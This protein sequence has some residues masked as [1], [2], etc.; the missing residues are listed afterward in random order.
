MLRQMVCAVW[1]AGTMLIQG[2][3]PTLKT[4]FVCAC[5]LTPVRVARHRL[6]PSGEYPYHDDNNTCWQRSHTP[7]TTLSRYS[8][9]ILA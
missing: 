2:E 5:A 1:H 6:D 4:Q 7:K 8:V 9:A 3:S